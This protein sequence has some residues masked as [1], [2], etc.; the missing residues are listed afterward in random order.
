MLARLSAD[1]EVCLSDKISLSVQEMQMQV[2]G[3]AAQAERSDSLADAD[4]PPSQ[5][6]PK[7]AP[8]PS[9]TK[10]AK[11]KLFAFA[12]WTTTRFHPLPSGSPAYESWQEL[13]PE[14]RG[15]PPALPPP[16]A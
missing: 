5:E 6:A 13:T 15:L 12:D 9:N 2:L 8:K 11:G 10:E 1:P 4:V 3:A 16:R 14:R 7:P